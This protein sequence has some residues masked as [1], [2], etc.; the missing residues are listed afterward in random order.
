MGWIQEQQMGSVDVDFGDGEVTIHFRKMSLF[1]MDLI[2][3]ARSKGNVA[4]ILE[5]V[6]V[7]SRDENGHVLFSKADR[8]KIEKQYD[9]DAVLS[10]VDAM[11]AYDAEGKAG[12]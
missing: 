3:K 6:M 1:E 2:D 9:P 5:T 10:V 8:S 12:N 4:G 7:R 11:N